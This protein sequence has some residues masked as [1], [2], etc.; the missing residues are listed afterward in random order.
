M[1]CK[2]KEKILA[3]Y[4]GGELSQRKAQKI[5]AHI[6]ECHSCAE[7]VAELKWS[8]KFLEDNIKSPELSLD[9]WQ[10]FKGETVAKIKADA[11]RR[12]SS[13]IPF[14]SR[15]RLA[16]ALVSVLLIIASAVIIYINL[17]RPTPLQPPPDS[18]AKEQTFVSQEKE[19]ISKE[20]KEIIDTD[21]RLADNHI[22][23]KAASPTIS[24]EQERQAATTLQPPAIHPESEE[25]QT[26][27]TFYYE[28]PKIK[29]IWIYKS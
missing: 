6:K 23:K 14:I 9:F 5:A 3:L 17:F 26:V 24:K 19:F 21:K 8:R 1:I 13:I 4:I 29:V 2:L 20:Q 25:Q 16:L 27:M 7:K 15:N 11:T 28:E 12:R 18:K 22:A 10:K